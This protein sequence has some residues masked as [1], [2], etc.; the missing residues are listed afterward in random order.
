[1]FL[2]LPEI[3][4][5]LMVYKYLLLFPITIVEGPIITVIAGFLVSIGVFNFFITYV[6]VV[7]GDV[8]GDVM[9]Y[10]VGK[11]GRKRFLSKYG[12][13]FG[14]SEVRIQKLEHFFGKHTKKTLVFGKFTQAFG[15]PILLAAGAARVNLRTFI[16]TNL[17]ASIPKCLILL[18]AGFYFGQAYV[19]INDYLNIG[20]VVVLITGLV[21][22]LG[23]FLIGKL[24]KEYFLKQK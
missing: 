18:F 11:S 6:I 23:Y 2:S 22:V 4:E 15:F 9:W 10:F 5:W 13:F 20:S 1:M 16:F 8:A 19:Q 17:F 21:L 24:T 7:V 12:K 3:T 14:V